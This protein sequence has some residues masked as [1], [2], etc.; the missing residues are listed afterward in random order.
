MTALLY[1]LLAVAWLEDGLLRRVADPQLA[2]Q[3]LYGVT[4]WTVA[5]AT[6][7]ATI[8]V[9]RA[10]N[11]PPMLQSWLDAL[12]LVVVGACLAPADRQ[13][14]PSV[15]SP[16]AGRMREWAPAG[17]G[18]VV[19]IPLAATWSRTPAHSWMDARTFG[20]VAT[21]ALLVTLARWLAP[22]LHG[23]IALAA[24]PAKR[25]AVASVATAF[26]LALA[27]APALSSA[28]NALW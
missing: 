25:S 3:P 28:A 23:R 10:A 18:A 15:R 21:L 24:F 16:V 26:I 11:L 7:A 5:G 14:L 6:L 9:A 19:S 12:S 27:L 17:I 4:A 8:V 20:T 2:R 13:K 1:I 22:A